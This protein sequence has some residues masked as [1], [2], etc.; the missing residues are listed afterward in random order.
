MGNILSN[1]LELNKIKIRK[2][3]NKIPMIESISETITLGIL[4]ENKT[5]QEL[6]IDNTKTQSKIEPS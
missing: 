3:N 1:G 6:Q 2:N 4:L 5:I